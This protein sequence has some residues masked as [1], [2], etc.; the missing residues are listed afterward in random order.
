MTVTDLDFAGQRVLLRADFNVPLNG[1]QITDE[2]RIVAS[3]PTI[4]HILDAGGRLVMM[5]HLGRPKG[6]RKPEFSLA[7]VAAALSRHL[8][9]DVPLIDDLMSNRAEAQIDALPNGQAVLLENVR[10]HPAETKGDESLSRAMARLGD[11]FVNDAF[12]SSHRSHCSVVGIAEFLPSA[13]GFLLQKEIEVFDVILRDPEHPFVAVLGGAKVSDKLPVIEN[14]MELADTI[15]I[16]GAMA[17]TFLKSQGVGIGSS[18]LDEDNVETARAAL[19][20]AKAKNVEILLP[21]DHVACEKIE[22]CLLPD[23]VEGAIPD[24][25]L[26]LDIGPK[27]SRLYADRVETAKV[28]IWNGPM[29][30]F[31]HEAFARGTKAVGE[32]MTRCEGTTVVGGGDSAAAVA[33]FGYADQVS[34]VSTGGG[35]SLELMEGKTLPGI[36]ALTDC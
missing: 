9:I 29:G 10:F 28:V 23:E 22:G 34:H 16:G 30:V 6:E 32:A 5:S 19:E 3:L 21:I 18:L 24:G 27:T 36:A 2:K 12:G 8:G 35:A 17:Y 7:P 31:E 26:G 13:A 14:L 4:R 11:V 15:L 33:Q 1:D 25:Q 20:A